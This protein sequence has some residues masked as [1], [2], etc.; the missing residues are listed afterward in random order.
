MFLN[1]LAIV[2]IIS[3]LI[4]PIRLLVG[5]IISSINLVKDTKKHG[6]GYSLLKNI[7]MTGGFWFSI[8]VGIAIGIFAYFMNKSKT[9]GIFLYVFLGFGFPFVLW[10]IA[11]VAVPILFGEK[12]EDPGD[13]FKR[14]GIHKTPDPYEKYIEGTNWYQKSDSVFENRI[15]I[16]D[17]KDGKIIGSK[18]LIDGDWVVY[19][20][21][22]PSS[23]GQE[24]GKEKYIKD[25]EIHRTYGGDV[26]GYTYNL[27]DRK[28]K[29]DFENNKV[30]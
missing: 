2:I 1:I 23:I 29:T 20:N 28:I 12:P 13:F 24:I 25:I 4:I 16:Y 18:Q 14:T 11:G 26:I 5:F 21:P 17:K 3:I 7:F 15:N 30:D 19:G 10:L 22:G 27:S 8:I 6:I 9:D